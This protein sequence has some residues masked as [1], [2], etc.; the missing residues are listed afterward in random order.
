MRYSSQSDRPLVVLLVVALVCATPA[1]AATTGGGAVGSTA[2]AADLG[3]ASASSVAVAA[4]GP[5]NDSVRV[6]DAVYVRENG[7]A[8]LVYETDGESG[9]SV[10][11]AGGSGDLGV[12]ATSGLVDVLV[13]DRLAQTTDV[14]GEVDATFTP[15]AVT[16]DAGVELGTPAAVREVDAWGGM[17]LLRRNADDGGIEGQAYGQLNVTAT[18]S[19]DPED[20]GS[21]R[22]D[23]AR[24]AGT[25]SVNASRV[26]SSGR[27][28]VRFTGERGERS[29]REYALEEVAN[30]Y[31]LVATEAYR[32][33]NGSV[34]RWDS[35]ANATATLEAQYGR[36]A[37]SLDGTATVEL[38]SY[39][40]IDNESA[41]N[42]VTVTYAVRYEGV[43]AGVARRVSASVRTA[44]GDDAGSTPPPD[45]LVDGVEALSVER[46]HVRVDADRRSVRRTW[47]V[48]VSNYRPL[49]RAALGVAANAS[50]D[51]RATAAVER[52]RASVA[53]MGASGM[54]GTLGWA[55]SVNAPSD[56]TLI[57][58]GS[59]RFDAT[60]V[61]SFRAARR[62][63]GLA[64]LPNVTVGV[65]VGTHEG[66]THAD[67]EY[68]L[69]HESLLESAGGLLG[70]GNRTPR[71]GAVDPEGLVAAV[72][73]SSLE[74]GKL[75]VDLDEDSVRV[76][77]A[78][79]AENG[80]TLRAFLTRAFGRNATTAV[81]AAASSE[82]AE[83]YVHLDGAFPANATEREV[84]SHA[85][86]GPN[87]TVHLPGTW[88]LA[89]EQFPT[90]D[91]LD[92]LY[93][94]GRYS[95]FQGD[96]NVEAPVTT[97]RTESGGSPLPGFG[98]LPAVLALVGVL[99]RRVQ[100]RARRE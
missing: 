82:S 67:L 89:M 73:R 79:L 39:D 21:P 96:D 97:T 78:T 61:T 11:P 93:F 53:A 70:D 86:V 4:V 27:A 12:N 42:R 99:A 91:T 20:V 22:I 43:D 64:P 45:A 95:G 10:V 52:A 81:A 58:D 46:V 51:A 50:D 57:V 36:I 84:R 28:T 26:A 83:T 62:D 24:T 85:A 100:R 41:S 33:P 9:E 3:R 5:E 17:H 14:E 72:A 32:V 69:E 65:D 47:D 48:T 68:E 30:G 98:A 55:A 56:R 44:V 80:S 94:L 92:S 23:A 49:V 34:A 88:T 71:L 7:D 18:F 60:N 29:H 16:G 1:T 35:V 74:E 77:A 15:N 19:R 63:R 8:V 75:T 59:V 90:P 6:G 37:R 40:W 31:R 38:R 76:R 13:R 54:K 87:T 2:G 25:V 66:R